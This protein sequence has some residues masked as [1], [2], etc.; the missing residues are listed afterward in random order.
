MNNGARRLKS[1]IPELL[2]VHRND[3]DTSLEKFGDNVTR[4]DSLADNNTVIP[5]IFFHE[6]C[7]IGGGCILVESEINAFIFRHFE[8]FL[9]RLFPDKR[10]SRYPRITHKKHC[11]LAGVFKHRIP[12]FPKWRLRN[13]WNAG[14]LKNLCRGRIDPPRLCAEKKRFEGNLTGCKNRASA[15]CGF[16]ACESRFKRGYVRG[17][18]RDGNQLFYD[19]VKRKIKK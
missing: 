13:K 19:G 14:N 18:G 11:L 4:R 3:D 8:N 12:A 9:A 15:L 10:F 6:P 2:A 1:R 5:Q 16:R 7:G 17:I